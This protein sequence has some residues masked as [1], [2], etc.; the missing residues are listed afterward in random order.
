MQK[1]KRNTLLIVLLCIC[2]ILAVS[3]GVYGYLTATT[4][5]IANEF[6]PATVSCQ[7]GEVFED[8]VKKNVCIK[9]TG[10]VNAYIRAA[11]I[12]NFVSD[13]G[14]ILSTAPVADTNYKIKWGSAL[15]QIGNDG[16]WY[17]RKAVVPEDVTETLIE[18]AYAVTVPEGYRLS[19]QI[20]ATAFQTEPDSAVEG[21][22]N[23]TVENGEM[24]PKQ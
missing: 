6:V 5:P 9:N 16:Y 8:G 4:A 1:I 19:I 18:T 17:Y 14:K 13:D 10:N 24:I 12:I 3:G 22:W 21:A 23:V 20:I 11:V 15:W 2:F 7:V